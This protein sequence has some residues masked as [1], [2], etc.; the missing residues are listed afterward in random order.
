MTSTITPIA[1]IT[2]ITSITS[3]NP[4]TPIAPITP[5]PSIAPTAR[6]AAAAT[7]AAAPTKTDDDPEATASSPDGTTPTPRL[8]IVVIPTTGTTTERDL[9][10]TT[11]E[12]ATLLRRFPSLEV[13][14][15]AAIKTT[16][17]DRAATLLRHCHEVDDPAQKAGAPPTGDAEKAAAEHRACLAGLVETFG[18]AFVVET[19]LGESSRGILFVAT[20]VDAQGTAI[21]T[22]RGLGG[23]LDGAPRAD[24]VANA[25]T[26]LGRLVAQEEPTGETATVVKS[27]ATTTSAG[28]TPLPAELRDPLLYGGVGGLV[29]GGLLM[30]LATIPAFQSASAEGELSVLRTAYLKDPSDDT[31]RDANARQA[32][33][34]DAADLW[35]G[36]GLLAFWTGTLVVLASGGALAAGVLLTPDPDEGIPKTLDDDTRTTPRRSS[37]NE[38]A[39]AADTEAAAAAAEA[40]TDGGGQ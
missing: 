8:P 37:S 27:E 2:S 31:L 20:A 26:T 5:I 30:G 39:G 15:E 6:F 34:A 7:K 18:A 1:S 22:E 29:V 21:A 4:I 25:I 33:A 36:P 10:S 38:N 11:T 12:I 9:F 17:G 40:E 14:D 28:D 35:N 3:I 19:T 16:V 23:G 13:L 32:E 24:V